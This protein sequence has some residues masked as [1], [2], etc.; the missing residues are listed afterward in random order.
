MYCIELYS[1]LEAEG[2]NQEPFPKQLSVDGLL[3]DRPL[4]AV[5]TVADGIVVKISEFMELQFRALHAPVGR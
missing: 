2:S 5:E 3:H 1:I 4:P